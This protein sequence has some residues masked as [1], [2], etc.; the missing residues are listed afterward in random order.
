MATYE[1]RL[2][3][4]VK[5]RQFTRLSRPIRDRADAVCDACGSTQARTLFALKDEESGRYSFVGDTCLREMTRLGT[6]LRRFGKEAAREAYEREMAQ[7][8]EE[9]K[10]TPATTEEGGRDE[11]SNVGTPR[12][13]DALPVADQAA[14]R[15]PHSNGSVI[16]PEVVPTVFILEAP[17]YYHALALFLSSDGTPRG[18]GY[19]RE[20]RYHHVSQH[21]EGRADA[22]EIRTERSDALPASV[23][24]A[25]AHACA[26]MGASPELSGTAQLLTRLQSR[27]DI[28][29]LVAALFAV[30]GQGDDREPARTSGVNGSTN[31][32][33]P[34]ATQV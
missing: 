34:L 10:A 1:Q 28:G 25:W 26:R 33:V 27:N 18:W 29:E 15:S 5:G 17:T 22:E 19:A 4:F 20:N 30:A 9:A 31:G 13:G 3:A 6:I 32:Q 21:R 16:T 24:G 23:S 11:A 2:A 8:A 7:R 12:P 14:E